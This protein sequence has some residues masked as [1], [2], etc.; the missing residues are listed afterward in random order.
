[1]IYLF[2]E[3]GQNQMSEQ[4]PIDYIAKLPELS[5]V[6]THIVSQEQISDFNSFLQNAKLVCI[7]DSFPNPDF[8]ALVIAH[9]LK[10]EIPLVVF[11]GGAGFTISKF[12]ENQNITNYNYLK[13]IKK[14]RFYFHFWNF[15]T[16]YAK[17]GDLSL[18]KLVYGNEYNKVRVQ[19]IKDRLCKKIFELRQKFDYFSFADSDELSPNHQNRKDLWELFY[20]AFQEN[21]EEQFSIFED[22]AEL[23]QIHAKDLY[24]KIQELYS[25]SQKQYE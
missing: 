18:Q 20:F 10:N 5:A 7:H 14:D 6:V 13:Q 17:S 21:T 25:L 2:D 22:Q 3:N 23:N 24:L 1:M 11:S 9:S 15:A 4:Y 8:R 12:D 19:V 16:E